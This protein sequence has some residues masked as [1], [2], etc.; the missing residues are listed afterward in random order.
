MQVA[1]SKG[2]GS[3]RRE[4]AYTGS[5]RR[6]RHGPRSCLATGALA[7]FLRFSGTALIRSV[8]TL[9]VSSLNR[10]SSIQT[11][12]HAR[13]AGQRK[14]SHDARPRRRR[15]SCGDAIIDQVLVSERG[16]GCAHHQCR[17]R[18]CD[19][20]QIRPDELAPRGEVVLMVQGSDGRAK[21]ANDGPCCSK[22]ASVPS[23]E[24][25]THRGSRRSTNTSR[26]R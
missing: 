12:L 20:H 13:A 14:T 15:L 23:E 25:A 9:D 2:L 3:V 5:Q 16:N 26:D 7:R 10:C 18:R 1:R 4:A 17:T 24:T 8:D 19:H 22:I 6:R 21:D 11:A